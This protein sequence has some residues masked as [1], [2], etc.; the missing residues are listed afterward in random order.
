LNKT[1]L[2]A[3]ALAALIPAAASASPPFLENYSFVYKGTDCAA[4]AAAALAQVGFEAKGGTFQA[5]DH[6]GVQGDYKAVVS[7]LSNATLGTK[8]SGYV[9]MEAPGETTS[10]VVV[11]V[12]GPV[13]KEVNRHALAL[14]GAFGR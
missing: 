7:C 4:K 3:L 8:D 6:V 2:V 12:A 5:M 14:K 13:Y 10:I 11:V 9:F 1:A